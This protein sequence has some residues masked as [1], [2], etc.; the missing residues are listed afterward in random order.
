M[1]KDY[2]NQP[3]TAIRRADRAVEDQAWI[4]AMLTHVAV[5]TLA[6]VHDGQPFVNT[7]MFYYDEARHCIYIHTARVGRTRANIETAP[8][9]CFS[10]MEMGRLLP[11]EVAQEFSVE[12]AGV[13]IFGEAT[14]IDDESEA[15]EALQAM[16]DKYAPHLRAGEDYRPPV[17][18]EL[19]R[20]TVIK[21]GIDDWSG[22]KKE[23]AADF[24][25][26]FW[27]SEEPMLASTRARTLD[28]DNSVS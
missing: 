12:Y 18:E 9:V 7:N 8:R 2:L 27:Y 14:I 28:K 3:P 16:L 20:T 5:G 22:K 19:K 4:K 11:A 25:G 10:V 17:T 23:V 24:A 6:T 15:I 21:V 26:A 1:G 13:T